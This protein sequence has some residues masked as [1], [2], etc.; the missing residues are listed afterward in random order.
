MV[1]IAP[2][3]VPVPL[4]RATQGVHPLRPAVA[5]AVAPLV[6]STKAV[7]VVVVHPLLHEGVESTLLHPRERVVALERLLDPTSVVPRI[8]PPAGLRVRGRVHTEAIP[9]VRALLAARIIVVVQ[10]E[11]KPPLRVAV[12]Q[13]LRSM[14]RLGKVGRHLQ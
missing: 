3:T 11:A 10:Q 2:I 5:A 7:A 4:L 8:P 9:T 13:Q 12:A 6:S 1:G 14:H